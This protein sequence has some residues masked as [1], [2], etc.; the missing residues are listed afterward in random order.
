[1]ASAIL[2]SKIAFSSLVSNSAE[3]GNAGGFCEVVGDLWE[4]AREIWEV[5]GALWGL[6]EEDEEADGLGNDCND[7]IILK[8]FILIFPRNI[9]R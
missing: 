3:C 5:D 7:D 1:M 8:S 9:R 6:E 4:V 2:G